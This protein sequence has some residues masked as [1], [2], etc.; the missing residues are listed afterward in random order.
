MLPCNFMQE[1]KNMYL[2]T[3][4]FCLKPFLTSFWGVSHEYKHLNIYSWQICKTDPE[5]W[6]KKKR[7]KFKSQ[8]IHWEKQDI[9][10]KSSISKTRTY[11]SLNLATY[12]KILN[13]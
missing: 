8:L 6:K 4:W 5:Y 11:I 7:K 1:R 12:I 2:S 10:K 13:A 9:Y 3:N